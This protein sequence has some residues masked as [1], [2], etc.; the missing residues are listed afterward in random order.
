MTFEEL[1]RKVEDLKIKKAK[2]EALQEERQKQW[3]A[4]YGTSDVTEI[5]KIAIQKKQ[6]ADQLAKEFETKFNEATSLVSGL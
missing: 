1:K 4:A 2:L 3:M 5:E 6:E